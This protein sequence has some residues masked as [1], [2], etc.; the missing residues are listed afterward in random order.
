[1]DTTQPKFKNDEVKNRIS[2]RYKHLSK[3]AKGQKIDYFRVFDR[4]LP[5]A[6]V[7]I[8]V[9]KD[10]WLVWVCDSPWDHHNESIF[11]EWLK[12]LLNNIVNQPVIV[13]KRKKDA[14]IKQVFHQKET[15]IIIQEGGLNFELNLTRYL[16]TGLFID[17]RNTRQYVREHARGKRILNLYAYTGSFSCYALS[18][19]ANFVT[20]VDLN[21]QYN[22]WHERNCQLNH[23]NPKCYEIITSD[24]M[25]FL[26]KKHSKYDLIICD[27]PSFSHSKRKGAQRF[28][29]QDNAKELI[30]LCI[31]NL[32][33]N[34]RI[35]F[36]NN[37]RKFNMIDLNL[38]FKIKELTNG[39]CAKDF[40][41]KW[42]SRC[43][44]ISP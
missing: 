35:L 33:K 22:Q 31:K 9:V 40:E 24:V 3:W 15:T 27:P 36:S 1:M 4:D 10:N 29:V 7:I 39:F 21:P 32:K 44:M 5:G 12:V 34:G 6:P 19:A 25:N 20:S 42:A 8:D 41:G 30:D 26:R 23:F 16:D 43:W 14:L 17:H 13:K 37:Y 2:K 38:E 28:Q 11:V 18:G